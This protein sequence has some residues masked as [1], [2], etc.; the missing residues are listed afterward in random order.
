[1]L[2]FGLMY[3]MGAFSLAK[4]LSISRSE[5]ANFIENYFKVYSG[6]KDF[7][8]RNVALAEQTGYIQ[9][10]MERKRWIRGINSKNRM[11]K[12]SAIRIAKNSPIQGSAADIVKKAMI[13]VSSALN[14]SSTGAKLLLQVHDELILEC[15][16]DEKL[17]E[18]TIAL[19]TEKMETTIKLNVPLRVSVEKGKSWGEFH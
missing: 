13:D 4:D 18:E 8:D 1:T 14:K 19:L 12:E 11:E 2:N 7:F 6:V 9:T 16:D 10:L 5:A 15:N 17:I 3:G